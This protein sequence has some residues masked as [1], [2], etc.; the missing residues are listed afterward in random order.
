MSVRHG[1]RIY[2]DIAC[3][4]ATVPLRGGTTRRRHDETTAPSAQARRNTKNTKQHKE[5]PCES[6]RRTLTVDGAALCRPWPASTST[7]EPSIVGVC[8]VVFVL[9][10]ALV[11]APQAPLE[12]SSRRVVP[13]SSQ[14]RSGTVISG[15]RPRE[16][17][18][19]YTDPSARG[20]SSPR[21]GQCPPTV[22]R[23]HTNFF[24]P[25]SLRNVRRRTA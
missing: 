20:A 18:P 8:F 1:A 22:Q 23:E 3:T 15:C 2:H 7:A 9:L 17:K 10:V 14:P 6:L 12:T 19:A 24:H 21:K 11:R 4:G 5:K 25:P 13:S 16:R